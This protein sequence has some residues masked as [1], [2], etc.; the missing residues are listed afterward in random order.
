LLAPEFTIE[1]IVTAVTDKTYYGAAGCLEWLNDMTDTFAEG[2]RC[3]VEII[4]ADSDDFVVG[5]LAFVATGVRSC[6]PLDLRWIAVAWFRE[7]R[8]TKMEGYANRHEALKAVGI[9]E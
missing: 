4:I 6:A 7:G 9:E 3:Q 5:R 1:N 2:W 8:V